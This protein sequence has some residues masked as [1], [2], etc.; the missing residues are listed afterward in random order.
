[1]IV[2][3]LRRSA[4][5]RSTNS[6]RRFSASNFTRRFLFFILPA[7][8]AAS[9]KRRITAFSRRSNAATKA[10]TDIGFLVLFGA[11]LLVAISSRI[12]NISIIIRFRVRNIIYSADRWIA[13]RIARVSNETFS[14]RETVKRMSATA[15][16]VRI[17]A[18]KRIVANFPTNV[19][20]RPRSARRN[21]LLYHVRSARRA[22][23]GG[24][25]RF[26]FVSR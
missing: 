8:L 21:E 18:R 25:A 26:A 1:M 19:A 5:V 9:H 12:R 3:S 10:E 2:A 15:I 24:K 22:L 11:L 23:Y 7:S 13:G 6:T 16:I 20:T 4:S 17:C 14:A